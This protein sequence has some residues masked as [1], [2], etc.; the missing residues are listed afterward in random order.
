M[1][2]KIEILNIDDNNTPKFVKNIAVK[3]QREGGPLKT[4]EMVTRHTSVHAMVFNKT[5]DEFLLVK[6]YRIPVLLDDMQYESISEPG[7][8]YE[9]C[10]GLIDS[11]EAADV[12]MQHEILEELGY[13]VELDQIDLI[14]VL[15]SS[16]GLSGQE[17]LAFIVEVTEDQRVSDGGGLPDEDIE[18]VRIPYE[19]I[20]DFI[21]DPDKSTDA[22]TVF[23][24]MAAYAMVTRDKKAI[25]IK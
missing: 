23:L 8:V 21:Y 9:A 7:I 15:K 12:I 14:R 13:S 25:E 19:E 24:A 1:L 4:W 20:F 11:D 2:K 22:I 16:V 3:Y 18:V 17:A 6:Q 10:A 5:T